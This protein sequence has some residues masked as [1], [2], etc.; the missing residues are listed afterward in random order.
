M[1]ARKA[2]PAGLE[3]IE[4]ASRAELAGVATRSG[5]NGRCGTRTTT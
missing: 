2:A 3:P 5:C 4:T 1:A